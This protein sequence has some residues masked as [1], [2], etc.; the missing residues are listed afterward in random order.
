MKKE[1]EDALNKCIQLSKKNSKDEFIKKLNIK[2]LEHV[3][4]NPKV[5]EAIRKGAKKEVVDDIKE[6]AEEWYEYSSND[7]RAKSYADFKDLFK[8]LNKHLR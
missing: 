7:T 6:W 5:Y 3:W 8:R 2:G 4:V 1:T